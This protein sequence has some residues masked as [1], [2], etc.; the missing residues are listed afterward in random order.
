MEPAGP[1][2]FGGNFGGGYQERQ[3]APV[4]ST[5]APAPP[6]RPDVAP[7]LNVMVLGD[8]LADWLGYGLEE[9]FAETPE[10]GI[11]RKPRPNTG[12]IRVE[13]RGESYDWPAAAR[14]MLN[15]EK[16][17]FVVVML[18][19]ADRRGIREAIRQQPARPPAGQK[20]DQAKQPQGQSQPL[21]RPSPPSPPSVRLPAC[22][23]PRRRNRST[24][25][26]RRRSRRP[27]RTRSSRPRRS[28]GPVAGTVVHEFRSEK[29]GELYARRVDEM[30]GVLKQ[31]GAPVF[32]V[33]LPPVRGSRATS[34]AVYLND[35]YRGR[36]EKAGIVYVDV[37]DG[38]VD[39]V[40][41]LQQLRRRLRRA[42]A[43]PAR[44]RRLA[45]HARRR[46]QA[47]ALS[48]ARG[49][50][51]DAGARDAAGD[52]RAGAR[53]GGEGAAGR[54]GARPAAASDRKPG[55]VADRAARRRRRLARW[56]ADAAARGP[57]RSR[58]AC[59]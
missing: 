57:I 3:Q 42:D 1:A 38:F 14:D 24:P 26:R 54:G 46:A 23:Q 8:S 10:I 21:N 2:P 32:W 28:E 40:G 31:K 52:A 37:W 48:R 15:A 17:D 45:F 35:I 19:I 5:R 58:R 50:P 11:V 22:R 33:G 51:R 6:R 55:D 18:G 34:D 9:A 12:L 13:T 4:D 39:D 49:S 27:R 29:W 41:Q 47:R 36:A 53:A 16:P 20:Q 59:W 7:T 56:R 44:R 25:K 43:A 30:I